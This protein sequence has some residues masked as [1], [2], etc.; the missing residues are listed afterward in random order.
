MKNRVA[1][2]LYLIL[3]KD[4]KYDPELEAQIR[5]WINEVVG[6]Q[7]LNPEA[8]QKDFYESMKSGVI[9]CQ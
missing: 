7:E 6:G 9:L 5:W 4:A 1:W 8:D 3:Q 2:Q